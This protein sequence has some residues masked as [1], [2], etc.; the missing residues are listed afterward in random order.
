MPKPRR[1]ECKTQYHCGLLNS[2]MMRLTIASVLF[3]AIIFFKRT[4][5]GER[6]MEITRYDGT[7]YITE[8][9]IDREFT[10]YW[11]LISISDELDRE[12]YLIASAEGRDELRS[13]LH[14]LAMSYDTDVKIIYGCVTRGDNLHV[15]LLG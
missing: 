7:R 12:G 4:N 5:V 6:N 13:K 15:E 9:E 3:H 2:F 8:E 11:V 14:D 1:K 10:G